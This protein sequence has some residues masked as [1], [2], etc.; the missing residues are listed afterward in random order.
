MGVA[1]GA[2]GP[3]TGVPAGGGGGLLRRVCGGCRILVLVVPR[4]RLLVSAWWAAVWRC[5]VPVGVFLSFSV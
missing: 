5:P 3:A 1:S 4:V 2:S